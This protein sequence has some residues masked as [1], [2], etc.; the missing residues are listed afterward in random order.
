MERKIIY[1][2]VRTNYKGLFSVTELYRLI[3]FWFMEKGYTKHELNNFQEDKQDGKKIY[4]NK[5]PY[6]KTS[7]YIKYVIQC[8][9]EC[10]QVKEVEV[11]KNGKKIRLNQGNCSVI[12]TGHLITDYERKWEDKAFFYFLQQIFDKFV[13]NPFVSR[14]EKGLIEECNHLRT[15]VSSFL[16]LYRYR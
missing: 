9:I 16:N 11:E 8:E 4:I 3:D 7:D 2:H 12:I 10:D 14:A 13:W 15:Q 5:E 1:D 6:K